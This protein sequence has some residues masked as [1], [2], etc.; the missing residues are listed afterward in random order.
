MASKVHINAHTLFEL[1]TNTPHIHGQTDLCGGCWRV[2][3][4]NF[5]RRTGNGS[6]KY[7]YGSTVAPISLFTVPNPTRSINAKSACFLT[8][9]I[10]KTS[11]VFA[12]WD[13]VSIAQLTG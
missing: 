9:K 6:S 7:Q 12:H 5:L 8:K 1:C 2:H 11:V 4:F 13:N 3:V 10:H